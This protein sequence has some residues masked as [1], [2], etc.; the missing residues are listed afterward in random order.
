[1]MLRSVGVVVL[2]RRYPVASEGVDADMLL[3]N[4]AR[5]LLLVGSIFGLILLLLV[6]LAPVLVKIVLGGTAELVALRGVM[7]PEPRGI[8]LGVDLGSKLTCLGVDD[9]GELE[10]AR[11]HHDFVIYEFRIPTENGS[12]GLV[13]VTGVD[14]LL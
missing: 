12:I 10:A 5:D 6:T 3:A 4:V 11:L 2:L 1:M 13:G 9:C 8:S 7:A 14:G